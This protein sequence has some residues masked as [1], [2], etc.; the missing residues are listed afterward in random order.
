MSTA[1]QL[2]VVNYG[3][4]GHYEPHYDY[5][6]KGEDAFSDLDTGNRIATLLFYLSDVEA[7]GATVFPGAGARVLPSKGDATFWYNLLPSG[8]GDLLTRHAGCPVLSGFKWVCNKWIHERAQ[9]FRKP[10]KLDKTADWD[11]HLPHLNK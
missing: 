11:I 3:I 8:E 2:Q 9:E 4:G 1:E 6:R 5:A 10:C 7:G